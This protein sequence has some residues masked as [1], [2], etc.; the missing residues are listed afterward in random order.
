M[1]VIELVQ[2]PINHRGFWSL[3]WIREQIFHYLEETSGCL[4]GHM[5]YNVSHFGAD[6]SQHGQ[7]HKDWAI[8]NT[9]KNPAENITNMKL[10]FLEND[11]EVKRLWRLE[12]I[13][14]FVG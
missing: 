1:P 10:E 9:E 14:K 5:G 7:P 2:I 12:S 13:N 11:F 3:T 8:R 4:S 6:V